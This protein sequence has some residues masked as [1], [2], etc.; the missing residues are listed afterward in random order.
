MS[1]T[2]IV[3][4]IEFGKALVEHGVAGAREG[5]REYLQAHS[6]RS[7]LSQ[8][9][10]KSGLPAAAIGVIACA[11]PMCIAP[12]P[13]R[14][15]NSLAYVLAGAAAGFLAGLA[16]GARDIA[17]VMTRSARKQL[18]AARDEHWLQEHPIDYA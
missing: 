10:R 16:W 2:G 9:A 17:A 12:K 1:K 5:R 11:L 7:I 4:S 15:K 6:V 3:S 13:R 8:S 18:N 14:L